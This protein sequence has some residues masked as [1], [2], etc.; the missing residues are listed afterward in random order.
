MAGILDP[1][2]LRITEPKLPLDHPDE[3]LRE[4]IVQRLG[5]A[6]AQLLRFNLFT[7]SSDARKQ[8]TALLFI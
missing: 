1:V 2:M 6:D 5:I 4:A 7:R 3:A 8:N